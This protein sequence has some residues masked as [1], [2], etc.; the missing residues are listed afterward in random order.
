MSRSMSS[1]GRKSS[2]VSRVTI[3]SK[4]W[5]P[6]GF[7]RELPK[8]VPARST[9]SRLPSA[10]YVRTSPDRMKRMPSNG[11]PIARTVSPSR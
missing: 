6:S 11:S 4:G 5:P 7:Q 3:M 8:V 10:L 1:A 9:A 2:V